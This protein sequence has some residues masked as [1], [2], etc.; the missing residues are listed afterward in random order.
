MKRNNRI[1]ILGDGAPIEHV[2]VREQEANEGR[3][4]GRFE[5]EKITKYIL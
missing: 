3:L 4:G 2:E 1:M 5:P